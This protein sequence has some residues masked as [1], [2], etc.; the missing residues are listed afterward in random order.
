[1]AGL[2]ESALGRAVLVATALALAWGIWNVTLRPYSADHYQC[3]NAV[4]VLTSSP[5]TETVV[6]PARRPPLDSNGD[7]E[8][9]DFERMHYEASEDA[10]RLG[11]TITLNDDAHEACQAGLAEPGFWVR[12][13]APLVLLIGG[14]LVARY[15]ATGRLRQRSSPVTD[16]E[17]AT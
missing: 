13:M 16:K 14:V 1:M 4:S 17:D 10:P 9:S 7:G 11:R 12:G 6:H 2:R 3:E 15:I 5:T 8:V